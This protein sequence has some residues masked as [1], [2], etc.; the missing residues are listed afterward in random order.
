MSQR[1]GPPPTPE[2]DLVAGRQ[3]ATTTEEALNGMTDDELKTHNRK[4]EALENVAKEVLEH[5]TKKTDEK[6]GD[7]EAFEATT[8]PLNRLS[9]AGHVE[10]WA[11]YL[12][13][14]C[15][16]MLRAE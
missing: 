3:L 15:G 6:I 14:T 2:L 12:A 1:K 11:R 9:W 16:A 13:R 7:R 10:G 8:A 5:W 4:L